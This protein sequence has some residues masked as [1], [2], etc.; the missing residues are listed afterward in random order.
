MNPSITRTPLPNQQTQSANTIMNRKMLLPN[1]LRNLSTQLLLFQRVTQQSL[2]CTK[3]K[4]NLCRNTSPNLTLL[5]TTQ[6]QS[7]KNQ[8]NLHLN[9]SLSMK[10]LSQK[11]T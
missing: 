9:Q 4:L 5:Q 6:F 8:R 1:S 11:L 3:C 10:C 7:L 2:K